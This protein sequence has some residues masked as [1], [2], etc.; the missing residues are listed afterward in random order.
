MKIILTKI[1]NNKIILDENFPDENFPDYGICE[2]LA[3]TS[4]GTLIF[5]K[6]SWGHTCLGTHTQNSIP[7]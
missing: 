2:Y 7:E 1:S 5:I 6:G 3:T 4:L